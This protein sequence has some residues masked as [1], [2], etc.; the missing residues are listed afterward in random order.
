MDTAPPVDLA[1]AINARASAF[2]LQFHCDSDLDFDRAELG[3]LRDVWRG[4]AARLALPKQ[5][6][7]DGQALESALQQSAVMER[8]AG[9]NGISRYRVAYAGSN[10]TAVMGDQTGRFIDEFVPPALLPRWLGL[11]DAVLGGG[12]PL[13]ITTRFEFPAFAY[14]AGEMFIAP[15]ADETGKP[16]LV[17]IGLYMRPRELT[18]V[19]STSA[20]SEQTTPENSTAS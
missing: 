15:L 9:L 20:E 16:N 1:A 13:R 6:D 7:F 18:V 5:H 10:V 12:I 11:F 2:G 8:V 3:A 14:A 4:S 17:I 19:G